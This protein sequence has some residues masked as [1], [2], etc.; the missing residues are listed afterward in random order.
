MDDI[1][2]AGVSINDLKDKKAAIQKEA[3]AFVSDSIEKVKVL[4][5]TL[6]EATTQREVEAIAKEAY[7]T[8]N[9]ANVVAV[10]YP[11]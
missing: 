6:V 9:N 1:I 4:V 10:I 5:G 3:V 2:L 7:E 11:R 8:L